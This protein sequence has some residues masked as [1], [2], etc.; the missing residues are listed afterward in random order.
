ML[1]LNITA[2]DQDGDVVK[3]GA[4]QGRKNC[5]V[6]YPPGSGCFV[7]VNTANTFAVKDPASC[8]P[9]AAATQ[10]FVALCKTSPVASLT[11]VTSEANVGYC[12]YRSFEIKTLGECKKAAEGLNIVYRTMAP[13]KM[14]PAGCFVQMYPGS[15][16]ALSGPPKEI[17]FYNDIKSSGLVMPK[18]K[19]VCQNMDY[20]EGYKPKTKHQMFAP[21]TCVQ[22]Y[23]SDLRINRGLNMT[24]RLMKI[25]SHSKWYVKWEDGTTLVW[26]AQ[27]S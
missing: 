6:K 17:V 4:W 14:K 18:T 9:H 16:W 13:D 2:T 24:G 21:G 11:Y 25:A 5:D 7:R 10:N 19:K 12:P 1:G 20:M 15:Q 8:A 23:R 26:T 27:S 22:P 3:L